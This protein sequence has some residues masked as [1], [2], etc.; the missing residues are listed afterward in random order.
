MPATTK[1]KPTNTP[2]ILLTFI[3]VTV[4]WILHEFAHWLTGSLLGYKM[5]MGLNQTFPSQAYN[6]DRD[7]QFISAA[8][9]ALTLIQAF[10]IFIIMQRK[11][12]IL[13]Y[14]FLFTCFYMRLLAAVISMLNPNDEARISKEMGW[15]TYTLPIIV[16]AILFLLVYKTA[17]KYH[18]GS[19][20]N[21]I[22]LGWVILFSS[23]VILTD[24]F[25]HIRLL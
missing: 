10:I 24:Q 19:R 5:G 23:V 25:F 8:G 18:L 20:F 2:Y 15:G 12:I 11:K 6:S 21:A 14:P 4:T 22:T 7:Y 9:P 17:G 3:A 16:V 1:I 13:L